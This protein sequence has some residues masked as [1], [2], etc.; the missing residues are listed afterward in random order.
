M[1][2]FGESAAFWV[3]KEESQGGWGLFDHDASTGQWTERAAVRRALTRVMP[4]AIAGWPEGWSY[5]RAARAFALRYQGDARVTAANRIYVPAPEDFAQDFAVQC[6]GAAVT[7]A[8]DP[9]TG[10]IDVP[11]NGA[12]EHTVTVSAR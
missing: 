5:D 6:D 11:C 1:D 10:L 12:G 4:E 7:V 8:R 3:W 2:E 9:A